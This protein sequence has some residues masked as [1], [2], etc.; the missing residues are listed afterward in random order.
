MRS[1]RESTQEIVKIGL[2]PMFKKHGFKK[3]AFHF[4]RRLGTVEH[5]FNLQL[6]QWNHGSVGQ[7]YL[8]A[9]VMFEDLKRFSGEEIP[10][11]A[12]VL[13][14]D[15]QVRFENIDP[16]LPRQVVIDEKT[17]IESVARWLAE[18]IEKSFVLPLNSVSS[19]Q[20]FLTTGWVRLILDVNPW[21]F[22][23]IYYY[24][25]GDKAEA[26][27][28]VELEAKTFADR[29]CTFESIASARNFS[30]D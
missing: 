7:F 4:S 21:G 2:A 30:F 12:K 17:D 18:R 29:G 25:M 8:N 20:E 15:F 3:S 19:T 5:H 10:K 16:Q 9:G 1:V 28:L 11:F 13:D 23:S 27:R 6:S 22:P 24:L 14:C 26:R